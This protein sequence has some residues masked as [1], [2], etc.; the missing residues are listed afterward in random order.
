M[1][2]RLTLAGAVLS[3]PTYE[4]GPNAANLIEGLRD[5][6]YTLESALADIVDNSISAGALKIEILAEKADDGHR[7]AVL[8]DGCGMTRSELREAMRLAGRSPLEKRDSA[9]L[10]RFG[11]GLKTASFSQCRRL[12]VVSRHR[13][14]VHSAIWDLD[15]VAE[16]DRWLIIEPKQ[17]RHL[18]W[19]DLLVGDGTL[20]VWERLDR[21]EETL[22][23]VEEEDA[24]F[25]RRLVEAMGHLE[26]VFHRF[27]VRDGKNPAV[28]IRLN[29][30][31]LAPVDP[32]A[33]AHP[34]TVIGPPERFRTAD[35]FVGIQAFTMPHHSKVSQDDWEKIGRAEGY[36]KNQGFYVYRARRLIVWGTWF[37]LARQSERTKLA[38]VQVDLPNTMDDAW[39]INVLK[40]HAQPPAAVRGR[41]KGLIDQI[42]GTSRRVYAGKGKK[43]LSAAELPVWSR[44]QLKTGVSYQVDV[45]HPAIQSLLLPLDESQQNQLLSVLTLLGKT[46]PVDALLLDMTDHPEQVNSEGLEPQ[47]LVDLVRS[48]V[49]QLRERGVSWAK[50][51][52]MLKSSPPFSQQWVETEQIVELMEA[53]HE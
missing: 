9:D 50:I 30:N 3:D 35:G 36:I 49:W 10:G 23:S 13:G 17:W 40:A 37:G 8:D 4:A 11:L 34:A 7:L 21:V 18:P 26:L 20:V 47:D 39:K 52:R 44:V 51:T 14:E 41:L 19:A 27:L 48:T 2:R 45:S 16:A 12:T 46:L 15:Y 42:V 25:A 6:G 22:A 24:R 1:S 29:G 5:F 31:E 53:E 38:R 43:Q 28:R 33:K 32:F